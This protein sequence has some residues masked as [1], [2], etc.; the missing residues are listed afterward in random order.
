MRSSTLPTTNIRLAGL[1]STTITRL[2]LSAVV[3]CMSLFMV[4][5]YAI[6]QDTKPAERTP[7]V[8]FV[9]TP[10]DVVDA[11]LSVTR[12]S[13]N[14]TLFDL[15]SGDGRIVIAAAK[16]FGTKGIGIDI[17]PK[18]VTESRHNADTAGVKVEFRQA[19][20]FTTDLSSATVVTLYLLPALNVKLRPKLFKEVRPGTRVVSH[21]F[22]MADW[23]A[24]STMRIDGR[25]VHYWLV[26]ASVVGT[27]TVKSGDR[28]YKLSLKQ[29]FQKITGSAT[30]NGKK[31]S[32]DDINI[33]GT[34]LSFTLDGKKFEGTVEGASISGDTW[35]A[36]RSE[37]TVPAIAD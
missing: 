21:A 15:G 20:L 1:R 35:L 33:E 12:V 9:P 26:P 8:I 19:D 22:D 36:T 28:E 17:D 32:L 16:R 27:W 13:K 29:R 6:A 31:I 14:D 24:D 2:K 18:R 23:E 3:S 7:D 5:G 25:V 37:K 11:M 30:A 10:M 34:R 4:P